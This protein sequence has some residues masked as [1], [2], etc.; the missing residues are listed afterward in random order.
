MYRKKKPWYAF[1]ENPP[2]AQI[3]QQKILCKD[4]TETP[5]FRIDIPVMLFPG[6]RVLYH[7]EKSG[8]S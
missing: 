1:H 3:L 5:F 7:P 8:S 2:L 6:I 4:I